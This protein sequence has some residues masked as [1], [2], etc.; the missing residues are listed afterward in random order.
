MGNEIRQYLAENKYN[1]ASDETYSHID[2][3]LEWYQG[4]VEKFHKYK[5]YN[6][7]VT[8]EH[9][10]Y[11]IGMAKKVCEDWANLLLNEKVAIKA[12]DYNERLQEIL[13]NNNFIVRANQLIEIAFALG[14]GAFVEYLDGDDVIIDYI[15][16]DMIYPLSWDNGDVTECAFGSIRVIDGNEVIY[17]QIHRKGN[18]EDGEDEELYYIENKYIDRKE[19]KELE[20]PEGVLSLIP[21]G[22]DKPLFQVIM[23]NICNNIDLDSPL[24][25]SVYANSINQL[26]GCDLIYDSY[27]NEF[28]LGRK[29]ILVP[30]A[31]ARIQMQQDGV[32]APVFDPAD[33]VYYQMPGDRENELKLTEVDMTIRS[34][35]H[36]LGIQ[37]SLD[38]LSLKTGLG[39]GRYQFDSSGVKTATE[40]ISDKSDLYQNRQKNAIVINTALVNMVA[41]VAFLD[42]GSA[43]DAT[44]DFDDSIIED[45]NTTIEKNIK[46]VQSGL[47]SKLTA[48]M[49]INKCDEKEAKKELE[50]IA[51]DNQ[52]T[53]QDVDWTDMGDNEKTEEEEVNE[54]D[55][56]ESE[57]EDESVEEPAGGGD[58]R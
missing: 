48:I 16:A 30:I 49:E 31:A 18:P 38:I 28:V 22:Y 34:Q 50:R 52:I 41:A 3:W 46:L 15:R 23:P 37:R 33:S 45:T 7:S 42:T 5:V 32:A 53:G 35:E 56:E 25:I 12:G 17:L 55:Q 51:G 9:K 26:K 11:T 10:R 21:T 19:N 40:V 47:R 13:G 36:E 14:T 27:V 54:P 29:R 20:P 44:V 6:G 2:E 58:D 43:V 57:V 24:G 8:T 4:D 1:T 39:T